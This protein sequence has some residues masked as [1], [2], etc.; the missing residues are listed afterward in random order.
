M[1]E[2]QEV[3]EISWSR[4]WHVGSLGVEGKENIRS[5][6]YAQWA[7]PAEIITGGSVVH[8]Y[9]GLS[10]LVWYI[11]EN[12]FFLVGLV[13]YNTNGAEEI[14]PILTASFGDC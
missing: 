7:D 14:F 3:P 8:V 5:P 9:T 11:L 4:K 1:W 12:F 6:C 2:L 13:N 10:N